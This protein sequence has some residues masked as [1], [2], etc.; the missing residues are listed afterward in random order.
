MDDPWTS[1]AGSTDDLQ[2]IGWIIESLCRICWWLLQSLWR[3]YGGFGEDLD[4]L[5]MVHCKI[6]PWF[7]RVS[8]WFVGKEN[9]QNSWMTYAALRIDVFRVDWRL[10]EQYVWKDLWNDAGFVDD[11]CKMH[12][13][14]NGLRKNDEWLMHDLWMNCQGLGCKIY[15]W[16]MQDSS[17]AFGWFMKVQWMTA[18]RF[19]GQRGAAQ[20]KES[21]RERFSNE[22]N[23][24]APFI[25]MTKWC[26]SAGNSGSWC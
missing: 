19:H 9:M 17:V 18:A 3:I 14:F 26:S 8:E 16:F 4:Y 13:W 23:A 11:L 24:Q 5:W 20:C 2:R 21:L 25:T 12:G 15:K 6:Y 10:M 7:Q 1:L 22:G